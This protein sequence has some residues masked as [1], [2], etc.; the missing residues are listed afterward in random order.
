MEIIGWAVIRTH[1]VFDDRLSDESWVVEARVLN[2]IE[3]RI[4]RSVVNELVELGH[5]NGNLI[6]TVAVDH[7]HY[8]NDDRIFDLFR[9]IGKVAPGSYGQLHVYDHDCYYGDSN[10][11]F[12]L[13][14]VM[15]ELLR[16]KDPF[17]NPI[18]PN[19][20]GP[21]PEFPPRSLS[22]R[23]PKY[24]PLGSVVT[25]NGGDGKLVIGGR[26]RR[27]VSKGRLF[28]YAGCPYPEGDDGAGAT[29]LFDHDDI[30]WVHYLGFADEDEETWT[31]KL[32]SLPPSA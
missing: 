21:D 6:L 17:F 24:L 1:Y 31:D 5:Y 18:V 29:I 16:W 14:L 27:D 9:Y 2:D 8:S 15:G 3:A 20:E 7:N 23:M 13:T 22:E 4:D 11:M 26:R 25:L 30:T 19:V 10:A 28:D 32:K 12:L